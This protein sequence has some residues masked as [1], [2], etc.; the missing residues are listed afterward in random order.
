MSAL[1]SKAPFSR[2]IKTLAMLVAVPVL[3]WLGLGLLVQT[4]PVVVLHHASTA[5]GPV[6][7]YFNANDDVT[8]GTIVPGQQVAFHLPHR[9]PPDYYIGVS[10]PFA[11]AD[12]VEIK[13][14]FSRVDVYIGA[15]TKI[16]RTVVRTDFLA[17][18]G[19]D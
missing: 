11:G 17:R 14:P 12:G 16:A 13:P 9:L 2:R 1:P 7:Y 6:V 18:F 5:T 8:K 15:D 3:A 10:M 19:V 4:A